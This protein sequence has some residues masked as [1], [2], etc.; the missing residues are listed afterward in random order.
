MSLYA[1]IVIFTYRRLDH[2]ISCINSMM[3]NSE[4]S[5]SEIYV[6][7]DGWRSEKDKIEVLAVREYLNKLQNNLEIKLYFREKNYGLQKNI[8]EGVTKVLE[9]NSSVIVI[10]EDLVVSKYFLKYMNYSL[11]KYKFNEKVISI[12]G[13]CYPNINI[14]DSYFFLRGADCWGWATWREK[15][16]VYSPNGFKLLF[17]LLVRPMLI[18]RFNFSL[19]GP[20]IRMLYKSARKKNDSWAIKWYASAYLKNMYT[21][22]PRIPLVKN[23]G[24]DDSGEHCGKTN[25]YDVELNKNLIL[26]DLDIVEENNRAWKEFKNFYKKQFI[27]KFKI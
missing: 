17:K 8:T 25:I 24:L 12:H 13:Y 7:S 19:Y 9:E 4:F 26:P 3:A 14:P 23:I 5:K 2:L 6:F 18:F 1:P 21:L 10:E 16:S 11:N 20:Y 15:W 22:Y 27:E